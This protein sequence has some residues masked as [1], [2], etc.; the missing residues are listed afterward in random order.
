MSW[1]GPRNY[2]SCSGMTLKGRRRKHCPSLFR[3]H[4]ASFM[5]QIGGNPPASVGD[6]VQ[7]LGQEDPLEKGMATHSRIL[8]NPWTEGPGRLQSMGSQRVGYDW[9]TI[10]FRKHKVWVIWLFSVFLH[11]HMQN[12][13]KILSSV[14]GWKNK[15]QILND[16]CKGRPCS[17]EPRPPNLILQQGLWLPYARNG[18]SELLTRL[19]KIHHSVFL[20]KTFWSLA[21]K[22]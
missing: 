3:K 22:C 17:L 19:G 2:A 7:S 16:S 20:H 11:F 8:E 9:T 14:W 10:T 1:H 5:A 6:R 12:F 4:R 18:V 15:A 13:P 21:T